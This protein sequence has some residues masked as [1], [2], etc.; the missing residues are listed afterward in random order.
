MPKPGHNV[1][2][3]EAYGCLDLL[4]VARLIPRKFRPLNTDTEDARGLQNQNGDSI[5]PSLAW[6][7][8]RALSTHSQM[9]SVRDFI[10][11]FCKLSIQI[12]LLAQRNERL[13]ASLIAVWGKVVQ[14]AQ[15]RTRQSRKA[16]WVILKNQSTCY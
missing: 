3:I 12:T 2:I 8:L 9:D 7:A 6:S 15:E 14:K 10:L 4:Q 11:P 5:I 1:A 16:V 13:G